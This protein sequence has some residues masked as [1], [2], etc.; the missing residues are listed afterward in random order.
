MSRSF[1]SSLLWLTIALG[2]LSAFAPLTTDMYLPA[3]P[4]MVTDF[5]TDA[6]SV[7]LTLSIFFIG[8]RSAKRSM[9]RSRTASDAA[10]H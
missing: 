6:S 4:S 10:P 2:I 5:A 1:R 9:A 8:L 3:M 7:Q